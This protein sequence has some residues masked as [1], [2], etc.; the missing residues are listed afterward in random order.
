MGPRKL[1]PS[2]SDLGDSF[3]SRAVQARCVDTNCD[4]HPVSR[5]THGPVRANIK[6]RR[7]HATLIKGT[8]RTFRLPAAAASV[9]YP[10]M[11]TNTATL[12]S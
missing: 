11:P 5:D 2:A 7:P 6:D 9:G 8:P 4:E 3:Q 12:P 10:K 1:T